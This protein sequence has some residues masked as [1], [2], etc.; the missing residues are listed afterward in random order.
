M[1]TSIIESPWFF[2]WLFGL[3]AVWVPLSLTF[4]RVSYFKEKPIAAAHQVVVMVPF[5]FLAGF[6]TWMWFF[7]ESFASAFKDDRVYGYYEPAIALVKVMLAFQMWDF[8]ATLVMTL[9]VK[10]QIQ[11]LIH[12]ASSTAL[13]LLG[14]LNGEHGFLMY[15]GAFFFGVSEVSSIPLGIIDLFKYSKALQ[16]AFPKLE[17]IVKA[18]FALLFLLIRCVYWP[19]VSVTFWIAT[20][21]SSAPLWLCVIW[22]IANIGLTL[23]QYYWGFLVVKGILKQ[24]KDEDRE[25]AREAFAVEAK[26][27]IRPLNTA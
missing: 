26:E 12:H 2:I 15:Y 9:E 14:L 3:F 18:T 22:W 17:E 21:K 24:L 11:H 1:S 8:C 20:M 25:Q 4:R 6:G 27:R 13:C 23:L 19:I 10:G 5:V 16:S 7:D